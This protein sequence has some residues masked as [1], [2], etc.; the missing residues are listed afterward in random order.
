M[1]VGAMRS[2]RRAGLLAI[3]LVFQFLLQTA[4][5]AVAVATPSSGDARVFGPGRRIDGVTG[6][7]AMGQGW[8][9]SLSLPAAENPFFGNGQRCVSAGVT[10]HV[11]LVLGPGRVTC[12]VP[13]GTAVFVI[14]LTS[15]CLDLATP[16]DNGG[17]EAEQRECAWAE[18]RIVRSVR[19]IVN[20]GRA[21]EL[22]STRYA[23]CSSQRQVDLLP[24]NFLG[25]PAGPATFTACGWVAW[26]TDL[27][28]GQYRPRTVAT[29]TDGGQPHIWSPVV[30][31]GRR[32]A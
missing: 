17:D 6:G 20:G 15:F 4:T 7:D 28:P 26:L 10:G 13:A 27:A 22:R 31:V 12:T 3:L 8:Y 21:V 32:P 11:L 19:L 14:G 9:L 2:A 18:L 1:E 29:F 30:N 5:S 24:D 25:A 23:I 16:P